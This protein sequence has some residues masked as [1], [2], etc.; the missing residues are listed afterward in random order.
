MLQLRLL[1]E[2][3]CYPLWRYNQNGEFIDNDLPAELKNHADIS[4][5]LE[6]IQSD[7]DNLFIDNNMV[8]DYSGFVNDNSR[9]IFSEKV[10]CIAVLL[11]KAIGD[12][13][14]LENR[15]EVSKL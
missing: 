6:E 7:F 4:T 5:L 2:Y 1:L 15:I 13:Y 14:I 10:N 3:H 12:N 8:F 11:L 9:K